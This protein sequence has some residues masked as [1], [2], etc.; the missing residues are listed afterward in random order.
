[1]NV[2]NTK[3]SELGDQSRFQINRDLTI[4]PPSIV[5]RLLGKEGIDNKSLFKTLQDAVEAPAHRLTK[6]N[7]SIFKENVESLYTSNK[8]TTVQKVKLQGLATKR[9]P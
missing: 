9:A 7:L 2:F 4:S 3:L 6:D 8:L 5:G 1:M